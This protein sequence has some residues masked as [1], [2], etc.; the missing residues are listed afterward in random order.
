MFIFDKYKPKNKYK[1][2][3]KYLKNVKEND[4]PN[5]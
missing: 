3:E 4:F 5:C 1:N 2:K